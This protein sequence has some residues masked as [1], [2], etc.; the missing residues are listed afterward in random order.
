MAQVVLIDA[1]DC[2]GVVV[3]TT[4]FCLDLKR[5]MTRL[6]IRSAQS[7]ARITIRPMA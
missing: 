2:P 1:R 5:A 6:N 3:S 7:N 4:P